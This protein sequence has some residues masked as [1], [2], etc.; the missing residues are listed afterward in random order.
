MDKKAIIFK[1]DC[2]SH[3]IEITKDDE[4]NQ[5]YLQHWYRGHHKLSF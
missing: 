2:Y 3:A 1:C 5:Y 4:I